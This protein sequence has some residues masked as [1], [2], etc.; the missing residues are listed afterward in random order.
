MPLQS[1]GISNFTCPVRIPE[2]GGG[3]QHT[4]AVIDLL[5]RTPQDRLASCV[6]LMTGLLAEF[7]PDVNA[8]IFP[9]LLSKVR[10][11]LQAREAKLEMRFPYFIAKHAPVTGTVSL[12]EYQCVFTASS[13]TS[14]EPQLTVVVPVTTLCPCS[15]ESARPAPT[16]S[17]PRSPSPSGRWA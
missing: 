4:V 11:Q 10:Q 17:G 6:T 3:I 16:T 5:A 7:L 9:A 1:V 15:K 13:E 12:M 8:G 14:G 2:K